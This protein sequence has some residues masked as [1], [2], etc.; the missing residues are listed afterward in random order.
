MSPGAEEEHMST[1]D[2]EAAQQAFSKASEAYA[3]VIN[4]HS[5]TKTVCSLIQMS[6]DA[7]H[8]HVHTRARAVF[9]KNIIEIEKE[10]EAE[11]AWLEGSL[12]WRLLVRAILARVRLSETR[13]F[14]FELL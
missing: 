1:L 6:L 10:F 12:P 13:A 2:I 3:T 8:E 7:A 4:R 14:C 5:E 9:A 11:I